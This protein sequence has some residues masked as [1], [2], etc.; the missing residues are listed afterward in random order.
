ML[1]HCFS[2]KKNIQI[3]L[4]FYLENRYGFFCGK[5]MVRKKMFPCTKRSFLAK[6]ITSQG[7]HKMDHLQFM[8][9]S[10]CKYAHLEDEFS[11]LT[12]RDFC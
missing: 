10:V 8:M 7:C 5:E 3:P 4:K 6:K 1:V 2:A 9:P 11:H 12:L